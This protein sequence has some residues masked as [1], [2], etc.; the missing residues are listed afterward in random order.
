MRWHRAL[1]SSAA[2]CV[3]GCTPTVFTGDVERSV[4][5]LVGYLCR[6]LW[7]GERATDMVRRCSACMLTLPRCYGIV[8]SAGNLTR[9]RTGA[10]ADAHKRDKL[11]GASERENKLH[12]RRMQREAQ[13]GLTLEAPNRA[14]SRWDR[15]CEAAHG[16]RR[17][18]VVGATKISVKYTPPHA[19]PTAP[20]TPPRE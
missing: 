12:A 1:H 13:R 3:C 6:T 4:A 8:Q 16:A 10:Q 20:L 15:N 14:G 2:I 11:T 5:V 18:P 7:K 19:A 17:A 9:M